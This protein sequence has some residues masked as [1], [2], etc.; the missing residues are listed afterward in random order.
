MQGY[1][2][3]GWANICREGLRTDVAKKLA[4]ACLSDD[5]GVWFQDI[6]SNPCSVE[7]GGEHN[8]RE[9]PRPNVV[10]AAN[11]TSARPDPVRATHLAID[12][13]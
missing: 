5:P 13:R 8:A 6:Q 10:W 3:G 9:R 1:I 2:K 11:E 7:S 12:E 4:D